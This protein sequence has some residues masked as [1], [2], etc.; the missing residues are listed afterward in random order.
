M[1]INQQEQ[2][3]E[4]LERHYYKLLTV[5]CKLSQTIVNIILT[6]GIGDLDSQKCFTFSCILEYILRCHVENRNTL[7]SSHTLT[8]LAELIHNS[9]LTRRKGR[10]MTRLRRLEEEKTRIVH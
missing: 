5:Q 6:G 7:K 1:G 3:G 10:R 4:E 2:E 8:C 9:T